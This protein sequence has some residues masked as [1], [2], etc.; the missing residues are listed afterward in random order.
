MYY[1]TTSKINP[2]NK[3]QSQLYAFVCKIEGHSV[4]DPNMFFHAVKETVQLYNS[5]NPRCQPATID[6]KKDNTGIYILCGNWYSNIILHFIKE[7]VYNILIE[8]GTAISN[9]GQ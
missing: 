1:I 7:N 9:D 8:N 3:L 4:D 5:Q 6:R 2:N